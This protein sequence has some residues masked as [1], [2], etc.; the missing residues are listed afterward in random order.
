MAIPVKAKPA[1][2]YATDIPHRN[3]TFKTHRTLGQAKTAL[4]LYPRFRRDVGGDDGLFSIP[5]TIYRL[6]SVGDSYVPWIS[7][8]RGDLRSAHPELMPQQA[9][10]IPEPAIVVPW[11]IERRIPLACVGG[12]PT[13]EQWEAFFQFRESGGIARTRPVGGLLTAAMFNEA[14]TWWNI[15]ADALTCEGEPKCS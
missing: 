4:G 7:V 2:P 10:P 1:D 5:M 8:K 15:R 13:P 3:P 9:T 11:S 6:D 12:Q 14:I